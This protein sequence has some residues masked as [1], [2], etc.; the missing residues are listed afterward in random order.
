MPTRLM[1]GRHGGSLECIS[2]QAN[3]LSR[4]L[5]EIDNGKDSGMQGEAHYQQSSLQ[6]LGKSV[7]QLKNP[8]WPPL[9]CAIF[10]LCQ[11]SSA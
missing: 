10:L 11:P 8:Q 3:R 7:T 9:P 2:M 6:C 5:I 4:T 1:K